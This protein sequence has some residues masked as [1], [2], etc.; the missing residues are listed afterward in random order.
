M[1]KI[2]IEIYDEDDY[3]SNLVKV[4]SE[5]LNL[6][7]SKSGI[8]EGLQIGLK[9]DSY[10]CQKTKD[11]LSSISDDIKELVEIQ[12]MNSKGK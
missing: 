12:K 7:Y 1:T 8:F 3:L 2:N 9:E 10:W 5:E 11:L 4:E 6:Y